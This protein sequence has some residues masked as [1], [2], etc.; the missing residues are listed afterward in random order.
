MDEIAET[1]GRASSGRSSARNLLKLGLSRYCEHA[2]RLILRYCTCVD[3]CSGM[4]VVGVSR[5]RVVPEAAGYLPDTG[6]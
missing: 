3:N 6:L 5:R 1:E 4:R 2:V